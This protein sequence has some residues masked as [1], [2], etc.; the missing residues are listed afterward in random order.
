MQS[1]GVPVQLAWH[2]AP[3]L[4]LHSALQL[5]MQVAMS[6]LEAHCPMHVPPQLPS[7]L[8]EQS[9]W[10]LKLP[11]VH[12]VLQL[13][14]QEPVQ[15]AVALP[16]HPPEQLASSCPVQATW[17]LGG[18]QSAMHCADASSV[19]DSVPLPAKIAAPLQAVARSAQFDPA[20]AL[21][22]NK[23]PTTA[24]ATATSEDQRTMDEPP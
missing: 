19:H 12:L 3:Q 11:P 21:P 8:P 22:A 14:M 1:G 6:L 7:Q 2:R 4:A 17:K 16:V 23:T 9:A 24:T 5:P 10:Q 13:A 15:E 18:V 20:R